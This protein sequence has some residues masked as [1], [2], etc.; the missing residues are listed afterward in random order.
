MITGKENKANIISAIPGKNA[1]KIVARDKKVLATTTK[2]APVTVKNAKGAVFE[3]VDGNVFLDFTSGVGV[4]NT[5]HC[6][7]LVVEAVQKQAA[8]VMH[9]AGTDF[10][11]DVQVSLAEKINDIIPI[12]DK[13][14]IYFGNSGTEAVEAAIKLVRWSTKRKLFI[15]FMGAFHGRTMGSLSLTASK[16]LHQKNYFPSMP[17]VF[18]VPYPNPYRNPFGIDGYEDPQSLTNATLDFMEYMFEKYVPPEEIGAIFFESIQGEG[19]YIVPP[20]DFARKLKK[21]TDEHGIL[22][23]DDEIQAGFGRT[24]KMFA[25]QHWDTEPDLVTIAKGMGSGMPIGA[26]VFRAEYDFDT[27]GAHSTTFGGNLV[28]CAASLATINVI[29]KEHLLDNAV[30]MGSHLGKRLEEFKETYQEIGDA[31]GVG[32]MQATE[33]V[34]EGKKPAKD[35]RDKIIKNAYRKGLLILPC[36][37][38]AIRYIPPLIINREQLDHGLNI[39]EDSIKES[40]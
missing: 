36:G 9:F 33:F 30:K 16:S 8:E 25:I 23:V 32:L 29:E 28:S 5:G 4:V 15:S 24:G 18:H 13:V 22:L 14:K 27:D 34:Y 38:S 20:K 40:L 2:L 6:H 21:M 11:Y 26:C 31:R 10:Y 35:L 17:G 37:V 19:G 1:Q 12:H 3:D 39:L 7:P